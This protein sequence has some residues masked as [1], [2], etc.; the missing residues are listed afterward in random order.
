MNLGDVLNF[1]IFPTVIG[2]VYYM[3][4][5][6]DKSEKAATQRSETLAAD[7]TR[8]IEKLEAKHENNIHVFYE[9]RE[10]D[11]IRLYN[12]F[13]QKEQY[14]ASV[15][16]TEGVISQI[17]DELRNLSAAVNQIKGR[18]NE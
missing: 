6:M 8:E 9:K 7:I 2:F 13:V 12:E 16:K 18:N 15:G 10:A 4:Q 5:R 1:L 11:I 3:V 14:A 17:F